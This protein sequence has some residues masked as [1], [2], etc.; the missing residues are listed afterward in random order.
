[1]LREFGRNSL[2]LQFGYKC[3]NLVETQRPNGTV[4]A[5]VLEDE[6]EISHT[7]GS[8]R[9]EA[10][11]EEKPMGEKPMGENTRQGKEKNS[12]GGRSRENG[13]QNRLTSKMELL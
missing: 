4:N 8:R 5:Q 13:Y 1:M 6:I 12:I 11:S 7:Q 10:Y 9:A 3:K 2:R